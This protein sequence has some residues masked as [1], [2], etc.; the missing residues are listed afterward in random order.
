MKKILIVSL[1]FLFIFPVVT[2]AQQRG[3]SVTENRTSAENQYRERADVT[4]SERV[5]ERVEARVTE[6][7]TEAVERRMALQETVSR[8]PDEVLQE[9]IIAFQDRIEEMNIRLAERYFTYLDNQK[10]I[11][12]N[13]VNRFPSE[14]LTSS[15]EALLEEFYLHIEEAEDLVV[16]Q[17]AKDY[18]IEAE[19]IA[20][21]SQG[22]GTKMQELRS[23]L[24]DLQEVVVMET[25]QLRVELMR[26][27]VSDF[28]EYIRE[29]QETEEE[30]EEEQ[31]EDEEEEEEEDDE[32]EETEE[33]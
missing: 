14:A 24:F 33:E 30:E 7:T 27:M 5:T 26:E 23:D 4:A 32:D 20:E 8:I 1:F 2:F 18:T 29:E 9:R 13:M 19:A 21:I 25:R 16:E 17:I 31:D 11:V 22:F 6:R 12:E 10:M 15:T 28:T 3:L